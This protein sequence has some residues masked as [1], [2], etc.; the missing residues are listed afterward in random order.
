MAKCAFNIIKGHDS[1]GGVG[2]L[3]FEHGYSYKRVK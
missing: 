3:G 1:S 2:K